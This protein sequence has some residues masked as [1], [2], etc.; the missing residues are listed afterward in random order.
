MNSIYNLIKTS[1]DNHI[2]G[3]IQKD[4][5]T[6]VPI[7]NSV[8]PNNV[9]YAVKY[10]NVNFSIEIEYINNQMEISF[11][12]TELISSKTALFDISRFVQFVESISTQ[13]LIRQI[14][15]VLSHG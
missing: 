7:T 4:L 12:S 5:F 6:I 8:K 10:Q 11:L 2:K 1:A 14:Q 13:N 15:F 3:Y 9:K